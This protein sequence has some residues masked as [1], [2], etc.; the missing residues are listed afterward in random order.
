MT[1]KALAA[2]QDASSDTF[3][4]DGIPFCCER[5]NETPRGVAAEIIR[6]RPQQALARRHTRIRL[7]PLSR[8]SRKHPFA[9]N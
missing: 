4:I 1:A 7:G 3:W 6:A 8:C 5:P 2:E 9:V